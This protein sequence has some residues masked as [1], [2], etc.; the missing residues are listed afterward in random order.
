ML[1]HWPILMNH[2]S[3]QK[4]AAEYYSNMKMK[5]MGLQ[6]WALQL[7]ILSENSF[8]FISSSI[9]LILLLK[10]EDGI[11]RLGGATQHFE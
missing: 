10:Y 3:T 11:A 7:S 2:W 9:Y 1:L 5:E 8:N 4:Q 6:D